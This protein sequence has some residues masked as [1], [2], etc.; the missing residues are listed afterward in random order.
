MTI[1]IAGAGFL[2]AYVNMSRVCEFPHNNFWTPWP[3]PTKCKSMLEVAWVIWLLQVCDHRQLWREEMATGEEDRLL[4]ELSH[5]KMLENSHQRDHLSRPRQK[6][7]SLLM[8]QSQT[9]LT[10]SSMYFLPS[11][12]MS[13]EPLFSWTMLLSMGEHVMMCILMF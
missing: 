2:K 1:S 13:T 10:H 8:A 4:S 12:P 3:K 9:S 11:V 7:C 5:C 6:S